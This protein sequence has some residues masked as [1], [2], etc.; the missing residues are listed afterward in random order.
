MDRRE[1]LVAVAAVPLAAA[2]V[3]A[4]AVAD[5]EL[6]IWIRFIRQFDSVAERDAVL[7]CVCEDWLTCAHPW[8][9]RLQA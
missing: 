8:P 1:F 5:P 2:T 3:G 4:C 7:M 6:G 9:S